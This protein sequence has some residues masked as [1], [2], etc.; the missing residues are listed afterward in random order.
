MQVQIGPAGLRKRLEQESAQWSQMLPELPRLA[1]TIIS[2]HARR[3]TRDDVQP[4][5]LEPLLR[6]QRRTRRLLGA[7]VAVL[8]ALLVALLLRP[9]A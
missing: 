9:P 3:S 2:Y 6:E 1:H 4:A 8:A 7:G 5:W